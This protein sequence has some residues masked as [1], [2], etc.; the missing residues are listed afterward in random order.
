MSAKIVLGSSNPVETSRS[1]TSSEKES[2]VIDVEGSYALIEVARPQSYVPDGYVMESSTVSSTGNGMGK[3][4]IRC[5]RYDSGNS[6]SPARTT[7]EVDMQEVS[8]DLSSH[9]YLDSVR[10]TCNKWVND[11]CIWHD[12]NYYT[13]DEDDEEEEITDSTAIKFCAAYTA[14]IRNYV[15]YFPVI[16]KISTYKNPPGLTRNE[17]SF[18]GGSLPFSNNIGKF[19]T[20]PITLNGFQASNFFKSADRWAESENKTWNRTEQ[21]TYTPEGSSSQHAWIYINS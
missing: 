21:W 10:D 16:T 6:F 7:F 15:R 1:K 3:L 4:S 14:G 2:Y 19:D 12:G 17:T 8:Y 5:I 13:L 9:P 11:G 20:P 18:S